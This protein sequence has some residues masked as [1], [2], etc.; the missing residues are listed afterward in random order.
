MSTCNNVLHSIHCQMSMLEDP[1]ELFDEETEDEKNMKRYSIPNHIPCKSTG[2]SNKVS[3]C[4][5]T[6]SFIC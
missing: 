1:T 2:L 6:G 3:F 5:A 4:A